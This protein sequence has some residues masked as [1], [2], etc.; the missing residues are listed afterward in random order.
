MATLDGS[1]RAVTVGLGITLRA[2]GLRGSAEVHNI[3]TGSPTRAAEVDGSGPALERALA[4]QGFLRLRV[5]ALDVAPTPHP[6]SGE[7]RSPGSDLPG[8][9]VSVPDLGA[10]S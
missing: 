4:E 2:P 9:E 3:A 10:D 8:L 5:I 6:P 1:S 7:V